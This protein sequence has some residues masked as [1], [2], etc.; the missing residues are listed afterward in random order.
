VSRFGNNKSSINSLRKAA[1]KCQIETNSTN[2][3]ACQQCLEEAQS[4]ASRFPHFKI[5]EENNATRSLM[6]AGSPSQLPE[7]END[8]KHSRTPN[9]KPA[10]HSLNHKQKRLRKNPRDFQLSA[11]TLVAEHTHW[12]K[13]KKRISVN[14]IA[15]CSLKRLSARAFSTA[16]AAVLRRHSS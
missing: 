7:N 3:M 14:P 5:A 12:S 10:R 6:P 16:R 8:A 13:T 2:A 1:Q 4:Y 9:H 15:H 11:P